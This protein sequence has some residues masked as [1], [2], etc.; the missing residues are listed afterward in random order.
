MLLI[1]ISLMWVKA[2]AEGRPAPAGLGYAGHA[3]ASLILAAVVWVIGAANVVYPEIDYQ[4]TVRDAGEYIEHNSSDL[5]LSSELVCSERTV[6]LMPAW[7]NPLLFLFLAAVPGFLV[8]AYLAWK[9]QQ[10][11]D[12]SPN[13]DGAAGG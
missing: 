6:E 5:P 1:G 3:L 10:E 7:V 2:K 11:R 13:G 8:M 9:R 4:C 12:R